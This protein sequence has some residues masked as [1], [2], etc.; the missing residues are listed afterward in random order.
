MPLFT[1][2]SL[3]RLLAA[4]TLSVI[5]NRARVHRRKSR[6]VANPLHPMSLAPLQSRIVRV[7]SVLQDIIFSPVIYVERTPVFEF[8]ATF[9]VQNGTVIGK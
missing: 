7:K 6:S 9:V 4:R 1:I 2:R 8:L 5:C 3:Q